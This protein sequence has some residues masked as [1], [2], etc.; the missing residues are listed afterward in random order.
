M[1]ENKISE[2]YFGFR[3]L[4]KGNTLYRAV[5]IA[6]S[7]LGRWHLEKPPEALTISESLQCL[8]GYLRGRDG[9]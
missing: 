5:I 3:K 9:D 7:K 6:C 4:D 1:V 2:A 8:D